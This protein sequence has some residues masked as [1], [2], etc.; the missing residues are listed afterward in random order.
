MYYP[1]SSSSDPSTPSSTSAISY[2]IPEVSEDQEDSEM[3]RLGQKPSGQKST[4]QLQQMLNIGSIQ[5]QEHQVSSLRELLRQEESRLEMLKHMRSVPSSGGGR[6]KGREGVHSSDG[7]GNLQVSQQ[8]TNSK[9]ITRGLTVCSIS[10]L[11]V[12]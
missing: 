3:S 4:Q 6:T 12:Y 8:D 7:I 9:I 2:H 1:L 11:L 10:I 5:A